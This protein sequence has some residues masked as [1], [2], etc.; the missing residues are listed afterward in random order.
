MA[1]SDISRVSPD[2]RRLQAVGGMRCTVWP[3]QR[4][5][6]AT[7]RRAWES[8]R[9][10]AVGSGPVWVVCPVGNRS[11]ACSWRAGPSPS[12]QGRGLAGAKEA[13]A[14]GLGLVAAAA[15]TWS[16]IPG[17]KASTT[18]EGTRARGRSRPPEGEGGHGGRT[19]WRSGRRRLARRALP[20]APAPRPEALP[21]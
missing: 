7:P 21:A 14:S 12:V 8:G 6:L 20:R 18:R 10:R 2:R 4:R 3:P 1:S 17:T 11:P 13:A 5:S 16:A 19:P 15:G 9:G